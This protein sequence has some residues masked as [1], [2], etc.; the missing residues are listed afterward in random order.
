HQQTRNLWTL[1][2][3][4]GI[5]HGELVSLA[6]EDIDLK[7]GT[8]TIRRNYTKIGEFTLPKTES[9]TD[10]VIH[11]VKPAV[12]ALKSQA[13]MTRLGKQYLIDVKLRE[14]GRKVTHA[15]TFVFNPQIVRQ[16]EFAGY[17]YKVDSIR[18]SW[19]SALKRA[20]IRHRKSYQ[21]RHTYACWLLSAGANPNFIASQMGHS[22]A[23]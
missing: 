22:N 18:D 16:Q 13:E 3:Y 15:C 10:R 1:A 17:H 14:Y 21:S 4:T 8:L 5:R 23:Q 9:G 7:S 6:W 20:G 2:V 19:S 12:D 11:L